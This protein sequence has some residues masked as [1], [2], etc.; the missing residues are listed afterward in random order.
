MLPAKKKTRRTLKKE[1]K[2]NHFSLVEIIQEFQS[3]SGVSD[4]IRIV[5]RKFKTRDSMVMQPL[6]IQTSLPRIHRVICN[7]A[8]L[9]VIALW[10]CGKMFFEMMKL[11]LLSGSPME[12]SGLGGWPQSSY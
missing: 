2:Q 9:T 12:S 1:V 11:C 8:K 3:S 10:I 5:R 6:N 4:K 7:R